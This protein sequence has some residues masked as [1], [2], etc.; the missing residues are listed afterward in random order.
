VEDL[1]IVLPP[2]Y[3]MSYEGQVAARQQIE[4][5]IARLQPEGLDERN[6]EVLNNLINAWTDQQLAELASQR[7]ERQ[8]V[9]DALVG[10]AA[11]EVARYKPRYESDIA[12]VTQATA[13]LA[14]MFEELTGRKA[15]DH[16]SPRP[17]R[18]DDLPIES[19]LGPVDISDDRAVFREDDE[20]G[21]PTSTSRPPTSSTVNRTRAEGLDD[22]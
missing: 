10:R 3:S 21:E 20:W 16:I 2:A 6:R 13:V 17:R 15:T 1:D 22:E 18:S 11:E 8:A 7:D 12:R 14:V 5:L 4:E 19:T 9:A